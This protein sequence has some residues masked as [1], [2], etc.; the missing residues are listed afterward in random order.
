M[1]KTKKKIVVFFLALTIFFTF[2]QGS[3]V[4]AAIANKPGDIIIT[5]DTSAKGVLGHVGIYIGK[6][7][8]LHTSGWKSAP[9]IGGLK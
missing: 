4:E 1:E 2:T 8:I 3:K 5:N 9:C 7:T 6:T